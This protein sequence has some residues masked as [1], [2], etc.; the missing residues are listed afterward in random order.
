[1]TGYETLIMFC[2][3]RGISFSE[4]KKVAVQLAKDFDFSKHLYKRIKEYSG[5]NKRKLSTAVALIGDP[6][7]LYLDEPTTGNFII[8]VTRILTSQLILFALFLVTA[9][10]IIHQS[11]I[12]LGHSHLIS[13]NMYMY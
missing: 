10:L 6:P 4:S 2:L 5:G 9:I 11:H 8:T 3:L 12:Y 13:T 1:M 7:I